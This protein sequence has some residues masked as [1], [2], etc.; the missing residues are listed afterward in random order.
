MESC[1]LSNL[2]IVQRERDLTQ[3]KAKPRF[4]CHESFDFFGHGKSGHIFSP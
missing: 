4:C 2:D 1:I 3:G